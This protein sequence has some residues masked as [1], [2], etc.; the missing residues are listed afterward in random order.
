MTCLEAA[1]AETP[2]SFSP[3]SISDRISAWEETGYDIYWRILLPKDFVSDQFKKQAADSHRDQVAELD[4]PL[5]P[6][7]K[8]FCRQ[9][10]LGEHLDFAETLI[11]KCFRNPSDIRVFLQTDP[12]SGEE[13][14]VISVGVEGSFEEIIRADKQYVRQLVRH[15]PRQASGK[16]GISWYPS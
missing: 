14:L 5:T 1:L 11:H 15:L 13:V 2:K 8:L 3:P 16:I 4:I 7:A 12:D 6:E 9:E 10:Q